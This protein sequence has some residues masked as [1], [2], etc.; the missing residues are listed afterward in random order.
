MAIVVKLGCTK[1]GEVFDFSP[2]HYSLLGLKDIPKVCP[3]CADIRQGTNRINKIVIKR[4]LL[5]EWKG[6]YI[7]N[8]DFLAGEN[9]NDKYICKYYGGRNFGVWGGARFSQRRLFFINKQIVEFPAVVDIRQ[10]KKV[11]Q[12]VDGKKGENIYFVIDPSEVEEPK[13]YL[14]E[15]RRW[16][17]TTLKGFGRNRNYKEHLEPIN[18]EGEVAGEVLCEASSWCNSGRY[19]NEYQL[20]L[21]D[22]PCRIIGEGV[23]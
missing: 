1:C 12:G 18:G 5:N 11:W 9:D 7:T 22:K 2:A 10:M 6:V 3:K 21:T 17:K 4:E 13:L 20:V 19:G 8:V 16:Y 14:Y 15:V 23:A